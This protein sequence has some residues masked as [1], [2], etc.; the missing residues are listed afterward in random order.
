MKFLIKN[1]ANAILFNN[2]G[3]SQCKGSK[4][5][6]SDVAIFPSSLVIMVFGWHKDATSKVKLIY[7]SREVN[8]F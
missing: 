6:L 7:R 5:F 1:M 2:T 3:K 4:F 8:Y